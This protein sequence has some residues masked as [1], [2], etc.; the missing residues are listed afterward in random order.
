MSTACR[1]VVGSTTKG[2][3]NYLPYYFRDVILGNSDKQS[4]FS[5][6]GPMMDSAGT[7]TDA[8]CRLSTDTGTLSPNTM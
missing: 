8:Q 6:T 2:R 3:E 1:A 5:S 4:Y 7:L